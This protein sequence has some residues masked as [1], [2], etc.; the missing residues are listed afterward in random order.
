M[1]MIEPDPILSFVRDDDAAI[2]R[3]A[4]RGVEFV[5]PPRTE[6]IG[7]VAVFEDVVGNRGK[8]IGPRG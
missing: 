7:K 6:P 4:R 2:E 3:F 8:L 1:N 5:S